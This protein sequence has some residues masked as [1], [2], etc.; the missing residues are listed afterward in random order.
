MGSGSCWCLGPADTDINQISSL[1]RKKQCY[2][3][4]PQDINFCCL[5][6]LRISDS[7]CL[8]ILL[9]SPL[10]C[11]KVKP[12]CVRILSFFSMKCF[13]SCIWRLGGFVFT[14]SHHLSHT[15]KQTN[16]CLATKSILSTGALKLKDYLQ[17]G[18]EAQRLQSAY[19]SIS[20][21]WDK[22]K[23][24]MTRSWS[25][26]EC[27]PWWLRRYRRKKKANSVKMCFNLNTAFGQERFVVL[28]T[29]G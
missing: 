12:F 6:S 20:L 19:F 28:Y 14:T 26:A 23:L 25:P 2:R 17:I 18:K 1:S 9:W 3:V 21:T 4:Q 29:V 22:S 5:F 10:T 24:Q 15:C 13:L 8:D 11:C 27:K 16:S 7:S